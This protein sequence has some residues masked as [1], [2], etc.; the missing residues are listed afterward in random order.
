M[1]EWGRVCSVVR[2]RERMINM[3]IHECLYFSYLDTAHTEQEHS[4]SWLLKVHQG[5]KNTC[6]LWVKMRVALVL[7]MHLA[8][9]LINKNKNQRR[10]KAVI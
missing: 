5:G 2:K 4:V 7:A 3:W 9:E 6:E 1:R 8:D 10:S